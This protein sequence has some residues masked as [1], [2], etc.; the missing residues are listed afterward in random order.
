MASFFTRRDFLYPDL[1]NSCGLAV[2]TATLLVSIGKVVTQYYFYYIVTLLM[3]VTLL[4]A[5]FDYHRSQRRTTKKTSNNRLENAGKYGV[6]SR[7][8]R[9]KL[10][11]ANSFYSTT[12]YE[13]F[14][15]KQTSRVFCRKKYKKAAEKQISNRI[16]LFPN[17]KREDSVSSM[18]VKKFHKNLPLM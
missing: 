15:V 5:A 14:S 16:S 12:E 18:L 2:A 13:Y 10:Q 7:P 6:T 1:F 8:I 17:R 3:L 9:P 11:K 4:L